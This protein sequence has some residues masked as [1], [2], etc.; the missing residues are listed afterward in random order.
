MNAIGKLGHTLAIAATEGRVDCL[1]ALLAARADLNA[2]GE[3]GPM[4]VAAAAKSGKVECLNVLI[5]ARADL[6]AKGKDGLTPVAAAAK[7]GNTECLN[8]LIAARADLNAKC[9]DGLTP[10][11]AA[12]KRGIECLNV[13][14]AA[15]VDVNPRADW[16]QQKPVIAAIQA[17]KVECLDALLAAGADA[18][19]RCARSGKTAAM[20]AVDH[21]DYWC[22]GRPGMLRLLIK[23]KTD[24]SAEDQDG[25]T[26]LARARGREERYRGPRLD[27]LRECISILE[28]AE[29]AAAAKV[30]LLTLHAADPNDAGCVTVIATSLGGDEVAQVQADL[31][32]TMESVVAE[33][34]VELSPRGRRFM[35]ADGRLLEKGDKRTTL[36]DWLLPSAE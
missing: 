29:A 2:E 18:T 15:G 3:D 30:Q 17:G 8:V 24:V 13:L 27:Q 16:Y 36:R 31:S 7:R 34:Q 14:L 26:A 20:E 22:Y 23:S 12:A 25:R 32:S 35:T 21:G 1:N 5:A 33:L 9:K 28:T 19:A 4:P 11:A 6:N 10:V